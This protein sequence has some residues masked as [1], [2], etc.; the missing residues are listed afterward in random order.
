M[1][2]AI[3]IP[4][5]GCSSRLGQLKQLVLI[6][7]EPLLARTIRTVV[8]AAHSLCIQINVYVTLGYQSEY[9]IN[10]LIPHLCELNADVQF[11]VNENWQQG[12]GS[13]IALAASQVNRDSNVDTALVLLGD[14][15]ALTES[16]LCQIMRQWQKST[17]QLIASRYHSDEFGVPAIFP[18]RFFGQ[19]MEMTAYGAKRIIKKHKKQTQFTT[20]E[21][22]I[23]D[24]DTPEQL[25]YL[26]S[27]F[28][29][30]VGNQPNL[31]G[32]IS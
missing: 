30:E 12:I 6:E 4:A 17:S 9:I 24:L 26:H 10:Q 8:E 15:W 19:L 32:D 18:R 23:Y 20:I 13:S 16:D 21:N 22:A 27:F 2:L 3:I 31:F 5:A 14:Q 11:I 25:Q 28:A 29:K 1:S 7:S